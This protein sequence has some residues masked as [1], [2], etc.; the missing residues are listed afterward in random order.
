MKNYFLELVFASGVLLACATS[1]RAQP[2]SINTLAGDPSSGS[3]DGVGVN[4]RFNH[5]NGIAADGAGNIYIADTA[6]GTIRKI[7]T[8]PTP[9]PP[10]VRPPATRQPLVTTGSGR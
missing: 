5:P 8:T 9:S 1:M 2:L 6:N 10:P 4:A 7:A 3:L